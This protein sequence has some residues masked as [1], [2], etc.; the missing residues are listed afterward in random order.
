[1]KKRGNREG[2]LSTPDKNQR[3]FINMSRKHKLNIRFALAATLLAATVTAQPALGE[4]AA[5]TMHRLS[6][7]VKTAASGFL[8]LEMG[9]GLALRGAEARGTELR[10]LI[11]SPKRYHGNP[12]WL[13]PG[14]MS[15]A[16]SDTK[17]ASILAK[18]ATVQVVFLGSASKELK[19]IPITAEA[20][21]ILAT[22]TVT[23]GKDTTIVSMI[24]KD[25][26]S[27][28][29]QASI[30]DSPRDFV[31]DGLTLHRAGVK[32]NELRLS[33]STRATASSDTRGIAER[34]AEFVCFDRTLH[35]LVRSGAHIVYD[36]PAFEPV[37]EIKVQIDGS[38][39]ERTLAKKS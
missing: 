28:T 33:V 20:C 12:E 34:I 30:D 26:V 38:D 18:G 14:M 11:A 23:K 35:T 17:V 16:C 5:I 10:I 4:P 39:C 13:Y 27:K 7:E 15:L 32:G 37:T 8:T 3:R 24:D 2:R 22:A 21:G 9:G 19:A 29:L 25:G 6:A 1:M 36:F 31:F